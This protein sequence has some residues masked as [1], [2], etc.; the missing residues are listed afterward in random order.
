MRS[1]G[2]SHKIALLDSCV[3]E[4]LFGHDC[5]LKQALH[6]YYLHART[7]NGAQS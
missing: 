2:T 7:L 4:Y 1:Q 3:N 5:K 6:V